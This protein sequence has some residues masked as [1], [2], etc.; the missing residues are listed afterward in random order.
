MD[1]SLVLPLTLFNTM[2]PNCEEKRKYIEKISDEKEYSFCPFSY[3]M[4]FDNILKSSWY[5]SAHLLALWQ[6]K[7]GMTL[8]KSYVHCSSL[9]K[10]LECSTLNIILC[11]L[12]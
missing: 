1:A 2:P 9:G 4:S 11:R 8:D 3:L 6:R 5:Y 7:R 12:N 10:A